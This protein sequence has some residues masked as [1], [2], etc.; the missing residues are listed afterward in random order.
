MRSNES[1]ADPSWVNYYHMFAC[2]FVFMICP[3]E[4]DSVY[5]FAW[6]YVLH[7]TFVRTVQTA[8]CQQMLGL[9]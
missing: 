9:C 6:P 7:G 3:S 1:Y 4:S 2:A 5:G 8:G